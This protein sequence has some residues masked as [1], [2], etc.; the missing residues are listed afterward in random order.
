MLTS[1]IIPVWNGETV[2]AEC[3][4]SLFANTGD[5]A[6]EVI[7][8]DNASS[9]GSK[10]LIRS[11][12]PEVRLLPQPVN[13][14]F[15]GG[16]NAG[17][18][19]ARGDIFILLNQDCL[20]MPGWLDG[21]HDTLSKH[22]QCGIVGAVI[23]DAK[24]AINHAGAEII[25]PLG[26]GQHS[27]NVPEDDTVADYVTGALFLIRRTTWET[28]GG[29]DEEF[30]PAYYEESDYCYR[31]RRRGMETYLSV[32]ARGRHLFSSRE[33]QQNPIQHNT[34]HNRSRYRF[35]C[36]QFS[37][38]ELIEF[39]EAET[40]AAKSEPSFHQA[41]GRALAASYTLQ[42][43]NE[44][45]QRRIQDGNTPFS[46]AIRRLMKVGL[47]EIYRSSY[48]RCEQ[49]V[50][51]A[52]GQHVF[53]FEQWQE[54]LKEIHSQIQ[55]QFTALYA[56]QKRFQQQPDLALLNDRACQSE[57]WRFLYR[58][59]GLVSQQEFVELKTAYN[60]LRGGHFDDPLIKLLELFDHRL[61]LLETQLTLQEYRRRLSDL[62]LAYA[63]R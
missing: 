40:T 57:V 42:H 50:L 27:S 32:R 30:F 18:E 2:L 49:L 59:L 21:F 10:E 13:L 4:R 14:G 1:V 55:A 33:W 48:Y 19:A 9:D 12:F 28:I 3:L 17:M 47:E 26:H 8:V 39:I 34:N 41:I 58:R 20:V 51:P 38:T 61:N 52:D 46:S 25:R 23:E 31:A 43:L 37:E 45:E 7:C 60:S 15:S 62:F 29:M 36:K 6:L 22:P 56:Q 5:H 63:Q 35:I 11:Q 16:V 53:N 44:I 54:Q 24:G